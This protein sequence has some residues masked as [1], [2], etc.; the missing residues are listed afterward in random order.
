MQTSACFP[1]ESSCP[2]CCL[3]VEMVTPKCVFGEST[4]WNSGLGD[5]PAAQIPTR[6]LLHL[7]GSSS[8]CWMHSPKP[9]RYKGMS[10]AHTGKQEEKKG[11]FHT[12]KDPKPEQSTHRA[13]TCNILQYI[14]IYIVYNTLFYIIKIVN[15]LYYL[16]IE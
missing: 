3:F 5:V 16:L 4:A 11:V 14:Y 8:W 6:A 15:I 10:R 12:R 1:K 7:Q 2:Q 13:G 9:W